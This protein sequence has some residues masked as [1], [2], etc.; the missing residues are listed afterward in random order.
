MPIKALSKQIHSLSVSP[1]R[2]ILSLWSSWLMLQETKE[3]L[4]SERT[5]VSALE[6]EQ[7]E[8]ERQLKGKQEK[9]LQAA[10]D[11]QEAEFKRLQAQTA[12]NRFA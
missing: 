2:C 12:L 8:L 10:R 4:N 3:T 5:N 7:V 9:L 6:K 1:D 11:T